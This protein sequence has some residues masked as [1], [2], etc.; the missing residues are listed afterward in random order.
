MAIDNEE[1]LL[2]VDKFDQPI[3][4]GKRPVLR[5][6]LSK[7]FRIAIVFVVSGDK[8]LCHKRASGVDVNPSLWTMPFGGHANPGESPTD[9]ARKELVEESGIAS[10]TDELELVMV[11]PD[12]NDRRIKW[13]FSIEVDQECELNL[14]EEEVE[15]VKWHSRAELTEIYKDKDSGWTHSGYEQAVLSFLLDNR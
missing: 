7:W 6:D 13:I 10:E 4:V 8:I 14:E 2:V 1:V 12:R 5:D 11:Y 3:G 15:E 9:T